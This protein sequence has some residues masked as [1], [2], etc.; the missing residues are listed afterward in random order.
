MCGVWGVEVG[1]TTV[2]KTTGVQTN[3]RT[4]DFAPITEEDHALIIGYHCIGTDG[5]Q[6]GASL[7]V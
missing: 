7:S 3:G 5:R 4:L 1:M 2:T 6:Y